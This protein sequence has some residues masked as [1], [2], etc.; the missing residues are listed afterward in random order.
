MRLFYRPLVAGCIRRVSL[1]KLVPGET[2]V[3]GRYRVD[4]IA[5]DAVWCS[6]GRVLTE[7]YRQRLSLR[8]LRDPSVRHGGS[9]SR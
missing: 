4:K 9:L 5:N 6:V 8:F 1:P 2:I 7:P 3:G